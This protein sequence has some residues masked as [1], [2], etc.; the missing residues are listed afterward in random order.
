MLRVPR[1]K[2]DSRMFIVFHLNMMYMMYQ[3][4][5][6]P[7]RG[8]LV[9]FRH[10]SKVPEIISSPGFLQRGFVVFELF[11]LSDLLRA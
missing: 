8:T 3:V 11:S 6:L 5:F 1:H 7:V 2:V 10:S 9:G 4:V